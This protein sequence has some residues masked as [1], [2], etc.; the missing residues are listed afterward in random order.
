MAQD[1][2]SLLAAAAEQGVHI[3]TRARAAVGWDGGARPCDSGM[4]AG[5]P[6]ACAC[7][8]VGRR[9]AIERLCG[10]QEVVEGGPCTHMRKASSVTAV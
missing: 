1:Q 8:Q 2:G 10:S 3:Y 9:W 5:T 6:H 4:V 7:T